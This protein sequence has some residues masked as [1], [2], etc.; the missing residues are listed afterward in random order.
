MLP[1]IIPKRSPNPTTRPRD[2]CT[3]STG[4]Q[5]VMF[6]GDPSYILFY[7]MKLEFVPY[8]E[9]LPCLV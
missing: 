1:T 8:S 3:T 6:E 7:C 4:N 2:E 5:G 9:N